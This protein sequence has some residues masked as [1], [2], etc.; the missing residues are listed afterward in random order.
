MSSGL[1]P[2]NIAVEGD[3]HWNVDPM[4]AAT[5]GYIQFF[6]VLIRTEVIR[7]ASNF[8]RVVN[9]VSAVVTPQGE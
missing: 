2:M 8:Y 6:V 3:W 9:L 1:D 7:L 5:Q 4:G